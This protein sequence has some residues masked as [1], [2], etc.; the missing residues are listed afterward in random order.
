M[1]LFG[2]LLVRMYRAFSAT[3]RLLTNIEVMRALPWSYIRRLPRRNAWIGTLTV[4][5]C[6]S[7][8]LTVLGL[9]ITGENGGGFASLGLVIGLVGLVSSWV[10]PRGVLRRRLHRK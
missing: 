3:F 5:L 9:A 10:G 8:V 4:T 1:P 7:L 6:L 2:W